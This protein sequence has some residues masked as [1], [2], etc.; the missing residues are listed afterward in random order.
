M[1]SG[2]SKET[3]IDD[4]EFTM[5]VTE[6]QRQ[7]RQDSENLVNAF[8]STVDDMVSKQGA[9][10]QKEIENLE[11]TSTEQLAKVEEVADKAEAVKPPAAP[12]KPPTELPDTKSVSSHVPKNDVI[13]LLNVVSV[14]Y[15][16]SS[17]SSP[18]I[19]TNLI[20]TIQNTVL[21][22]LGQAPAGKGI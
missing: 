1:G 10:P 5:K 8:F 6:Q 13:V 21:D 7:I 11:A 4:T 17:S 15:E 2:P 22:L 9:P 19:L 14:M 16:Q 3:V 12:A 18:V 20:D